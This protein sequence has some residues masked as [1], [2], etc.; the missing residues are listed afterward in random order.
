MAL[1]E[2]EGVADAAREAKDLIE[3]AQ[4]GNFSNFQNY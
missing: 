4:W 2:N 3:I 1:L